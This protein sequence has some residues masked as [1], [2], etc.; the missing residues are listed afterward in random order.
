LN[1][2]LQF[3]NNTEKPVEPFKFGSAAP[4]SNAFQFSANQNVS[5]PVKFGQTS[6]TFSTT[7]FS[8]FGSSVP[9]QITSFGNV[10]PS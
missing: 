8:G 6:N 3:K 10:Q 2:P 5:G 4:A 7:T 9:P 1:Q